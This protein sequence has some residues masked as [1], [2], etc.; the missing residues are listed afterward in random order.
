VA[1]GPSDA[2]SAEEVQEHNPGGSWG[3]E[4]GY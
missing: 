1:G 2:A 4:R 3:V